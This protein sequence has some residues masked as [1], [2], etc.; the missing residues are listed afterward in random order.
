[1]D[2]TITPRTHCNLCSPYGKGKKTARKPISLRTRAGRPV[3]KDRD[4]RATARVMGEVVAR[5]PDHPVRIVR[6]RRVMWRTIRAASEGG[7]PEP[8]P[9][10]PQPP[11]LPPDPVPDPGIPPKPDLPPG[12]PPEPVKQ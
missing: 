3:T 8:V 12:P 1:L 11:D 7:V 6:S 2:A 9:P 10:A 4:G 5:E